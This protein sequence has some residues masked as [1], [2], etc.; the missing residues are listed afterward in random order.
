MTIL[1]DSSNPAADATDVSAR[2]IRV[3]DLPVRVFHWALA[4]SFAGA[5]VLA[6][7]E[8][9]RQI[10]VMF[11][12]TV[13]GL[14]A[15]RLIWGFVGTRYARFTSFAFG[16]RRALAYLRGLMAGNAPRH[17]GHNPLGSWAVYAILGVAAATGITGWMNLNEIGGE[18]VEEVHEVLANG[19]LVLVGMHIAGVLVSSLVHRENLARAMVTGYKDGAA[20]DG[21]PTLRPVLGAI[22]ATGVLGFWFWWT[23]AGGGDVASGYAQS[24][25]EA[26]E[27][28]DED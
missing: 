23:V 10:H 14:V 11:G 21:S 5:Y 19:W 12:Y 15:F 3:W 18:A 1:A 16:P 2:R 8:R 9:Q 28:D 6:E 25:V 13:L 4:L 22:V 24:T 26:G 7:S 27:R 17:V 20:R